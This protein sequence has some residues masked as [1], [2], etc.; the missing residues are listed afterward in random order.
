MT[1]PT[2]ELELLARL[3]VQIAEPYDGGVTATGEASSIIPII[4]GTVEG[5]LLE[6]E[7]LPLGADW[8]VARTDGTFKV[9]ARYLIRTIDGTV[10]TVTNTGVIAA[11]QDP[12]GLTSPRIEA[13]QGRYAWLNDAVL[14][15]T[16][17]PVFA[18]DAP[19]G[20]SLEFH[21]VRTV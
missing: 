18:N 19:V 5:P 16:L 9:A 21:C 10:L 6:G 7:I 2:L 1:H 15:G 3:Q 4:G 17:S 11:G 13:P 20:V 14:I 8:G 12:I